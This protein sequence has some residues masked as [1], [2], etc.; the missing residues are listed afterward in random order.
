M[1]RLTAHALLCKISLSLL[2][3][4]ARSKKDGGWTR[5]FTTCQLFLIKAKSLKVRKKF[6]LKKIGVFAFMNS[7][8]TTFFGRETVSKWRQ[9][10][11][12]QGLAAI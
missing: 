12:E 3:N 9:E 6:I 11:A 5:Y 8:I 2:L 7:P 10:I 1:S 4:S